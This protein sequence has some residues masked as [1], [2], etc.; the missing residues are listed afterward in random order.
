MIASGE[1]VD[2]SCVLA[3]A[4]CHDLINLSKDHPERKNAS[5]VSAKEA[6][7][8]LINSGFNEKEIEI[9]NKGIIEHSFSKGAKPTCLEAAIVQDADRLDALGA[10]GILRCAAVATQMKTRFYD[11]TDP[12]A[13]GRELND[14][15]FMLDH[16]FVKLFKLP[17]LMNTE[18][19]RLLSLERVQYMKSFIDELVN[20]I[21]PI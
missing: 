16:Y 6:R 7:P 17:E 1:T 13:K 9:I 11:S 4:Y 12:F 21:G 19:G 8:L 5:T 10:V 3:T 15:S 14:K 2:I 18:K 20:E